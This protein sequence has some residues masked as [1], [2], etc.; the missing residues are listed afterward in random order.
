MAAVGEAAAP[1]TW[2]RRSVWLSRIESPLA[3][4]YLVL[5]ST[6]ALTVI[7]LVMVLSSSSVTSLKGGTGSSYTEFLNQARFAALGLP[8]AWVASRM[9]KRFWTRFA[10]PM[11]GVGL[12]L[13]V[14]VFT[15][16]G[17]EQG[18]NRAWI[19]LGGG[20]VLQPA[21]VCKIALIVWGAT[22]LAR[23]RPLL[24][25]TS[26]LLVPVVPGALAVLGL[27]L[28]GRDL[29]TAMILIAVVATLLF[30]AGAPMRWFT[31]GGGLAVSAVLLLVT[32][33]QN[34]SNRLAVWLSGCANPDMLG[35]WQPAHGRYALATGGWWGVGLGGSRE[36]WNYL[37]AA[38]NDYIFSIIGEE[39]GL[40]GTFA[41]L[42]LF[43]LLALGLYRLVV[44]SDDLMVKIASAGVF[45]WILLQAVI[46]MSVVV[47]LLP[48]IGLPLPLVS[49]GGSALVT[50]LFALGIV[51]GF[52]R[53]VPGAPEALAARGSVVKRSLAVVPLRVRRTGRS[54]P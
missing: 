52:A 48:V 4:Y 45:T 30:V 5:G 1:S 46:N 2:T 20:I 38:H 24:N 49:S 28:L 50:T 37:P 16:M 51:L 39:L 8:L 13:Q 22:V 23:K 6:L 15:G 42:A 35:C 14:L 12:A 34:R 41:I 32:G 40:P 25:R 54:Q 21:E 18:G 27:V 7:G 33:S 11:L 10:W 26:H 47:G 19:Y 17:R 31:I 9:P 36:K 53:R 3:P 29:G 43:G 44:T